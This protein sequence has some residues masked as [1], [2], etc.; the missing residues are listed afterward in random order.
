[1]LLILTGFSLPVFPKILPVLIILLLLEWLINPELKRNFLAV[2]N[3]PLLLLLINLY[4]FYTSGLIYSD[5]LSFGLADLET[6]FSLLVFPLVFSTSA[7]ISSQVLKNVFKA[8]I[9]GNLLV[10]IYCLILALNNYMKENNFDLVVG[11]DLSLILHPSYFSMYIVLASIILLNELYNAQSKFLTKIGIVL[12]LLVFTVAIFLLSSKIGVI[13][14]ILITFFFLLFQIISKR[15]YLQGFLS[16]GIIALLIFTAFYFSPNISAR[17]KF[18]FGA[19][20]TPV[21]PG[22]SESSALRV[23]TWK[24]AGEIIRENPIIG[25]GT[26]DIKDELIKKYEANGMVYALKL[27]LNAHNQFLQTAG[28]LGIIGLLLLLL[29]FVVPFYI[30]AK[31]KNIIYFFFLLLVLLNFTVESMLETQAGVIFFAFFSSIFIITKNQDYNDTI[32][33][34]KN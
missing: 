31:E 32:F 34:P 26:G 27:R 6:K 19:I 15:L 14:F 13:S 5:N 4:L 12:I 33:S 22:S 17:F 1:M 29:C 10:F 30:S 16:L 25:V 7:Y 3:S 21:Q 11:S 23:L 20:N 18:A 2:V 28:T 9:I 8:F 24:T